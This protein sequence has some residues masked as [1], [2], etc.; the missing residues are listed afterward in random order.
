MILWFLLLIGVMIVIHELGHYWAARWFDIRV[1]TFSFGFGPRLFGFKKGET[2]FRVSAIPFGGFVRMAGEQPG[3]ANADDPR[4]FQAKPRW[5]RLIVVFGGP[6]M[7][8][9]LA[10][11]ILAGLFMWRYP[12]QPPQ[13]VSGIVGIVLPDSAAARAGIQEGD[14]ITALDGAQY[15]SWEDITLKVIGSPGQPLRVV[16]D[17]GGVEKEAT[18][19]PEIDKRDGIGTAGWGEQME[20][21][22]GGVQAGMDA[23]RKGLRAGDLLVSINGEPIRSSAKIRE[24][25]KKS[26]GKPVDITFRRDGTNHTVSVVPAQ[27]ELEGQKSWMIG[28]QLEPRFVFVRLGPIEAVRESIKSNIKGATLIYQFLH[29]IIE[30]RMSPRSLEGPIRM[31]QISGEAAK[32]GI[33][34]YLSLMA[35]VS[36]NLAIF[37]LLPIPILDGGSILLLLVE[38]IFRRDLSLQVKET[39]LKFGFV[40]L[41]MVVMF[42]IYNDIRK[43][44]PS[45]G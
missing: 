26:E 12:K 45:G 3:D 20:I 39:V 33:T 13:E 1:D 19:V 22:I 35:M 37:N 5:Q 25:V 17:R 23:E 21:Q 10:I 16:F 31:A 40:F 43:V 42:V 11:A 28:V 2:D 6:F 38:M 36:L 32:E 41:L 34:S 4:S 9:V 44:L 14:R 8:I 27:G 7:N 24:T 15:P 18:L 29:G 30:R